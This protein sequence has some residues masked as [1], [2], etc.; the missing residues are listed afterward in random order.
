MIQLAWN[1]NRGFSA[2]PFY[3]IP[4]WCVETQREA[5]YIEHERTHCR[6]QAWWTPFWWTAWVFSKKFR[7][8]EESEAY[9]R[10]LIVARRTGDIDINYYANELSKGYF[11]M[12]GYVEAYRWLVRILE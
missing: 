6:R 7:W 2:W 5:S 8:A 3:V 10:E 4:R 9:R 11:G 12:I 1:I